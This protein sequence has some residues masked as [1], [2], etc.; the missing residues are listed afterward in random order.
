MNGVKRMTQVL[1]DD[2]WLN[3]MKL[4]I[5]EQR[6]IV[7][8]CHDD[9]IT[10]GRYCEALLVSLH[11]RSFSTKVIL[12]HAEPSDLVIMQTLIQHDST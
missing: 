1:M 7:V 8:A 3:T 4:A 10:H 11:A 9:R 12:Y 5:E 6:I 2:M